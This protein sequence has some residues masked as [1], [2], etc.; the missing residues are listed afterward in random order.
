MSSHYDAGGRYPTQGV[1]GQ[2]AIPAAYPYHHS[3]TTRYAPVPA[4]GTLWEAGRF[5][6]VVG[7][8]GAGAVNLRRVQADA[9]G[10][11]EAAIDTL[12]TGVA[13]GVATAGATLVASQFRGSVL[14]LLATLATGTAL[15]YAFTARD[16]ATATL[17]NTGAASPNGQ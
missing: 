3:H 4:I 14:P 16:Q 7:L 13:A 10:R 8:C 15:M 1:D 9:L 5:G 17:A 2:A 11:R 6:A 12:R